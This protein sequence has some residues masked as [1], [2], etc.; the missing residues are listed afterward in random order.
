MQKALPSTEAARVMPA[1]EAAAVTQGPPNNGRG[2]LPPLGIGDQI[3]IAVFGQPDLS[4]EV[5]VGESG[6][7]MVPL[8][9]T[10]NVLNMSAAQLE[11]MVAMRLKMAATCKTPVCRYRSGN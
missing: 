7:I 10:L 11:A 1:K 3:T 5:T 4:A 8:I 9:G 2:G 6:T